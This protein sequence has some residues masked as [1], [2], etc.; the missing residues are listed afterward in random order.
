MTCGI[1]NYGLSSRSCCHLMALDSSIMAG[2]H[3]QKDVKAVCF[4]HTTKIRL[5]VIAVPDLA[6]SEM[7]FLQRPTRAPANEPDKAGS[8]S[9]EKE[10]RRVEREQV[11][12]STFFKPRGEPNIVR[13]SR[14]TS[15]HISE[16]QPTSMKQI[17]DRYGKRHLSLQISDRDVTPGQRSQFSGTY[18]TP[19]SFSHP[20][21]LPRQE[22]DGTTCVTWSETQMTPEVT[23]SLRRR[24]IGQ[25]Q[26][27]PIPDSIR[28]SLE[29]TGIFRDTGIGSTTA[30]NP[31]R[32][33]KSPETRTGER[34]IPSTPS[35]R[36]RLLMR[37]RNT[38][39]LSESHGQR[40]VL[41]KER[42]SYPDDSQKE[43][44]RSHRTHE[45][46]L[47]SKECPQGERS[48]PSS[49][50]HSG[51]IRST[52]PP[53]ALSRSQNL[54]DSICPPMTREQLAQKARIRRQPDTL[55]V[56][57]KVGMPPNKNEVQVINPNSHDGQ[58]K[59]GISN[60]ND[61]TPAECTTTLSKAVETVNRSRVEGTAHHLQETAGQDI[62]STQP[63][64]PIYVAQPQVTSI[65]EDTGCIMNESPATLDQ[66]NQ[67]QAPLIAANYATTPI[68]GPFVNWITRPTS[69]APPIAEY[70]HENPVQFRYTEHIPYELDNIGEQ[71]GLPFEDEN[72]QVPTYLEHTKYDL[73][74]DEYATLAMQD[75]DFVYDGTTGL[76]WPVQ[77]IIPQS[78]EGQEQFTYQEMGDSELWLGDVT[79]Q[80]GGD[81]FSRSNELY[82]A[83]TGYEQ[84]NNEADDTL[85]GFWRPHRTY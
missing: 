53:A 44:D 28:R 39:L 9:R 73:W 60:T 36:N 54:H 30:L 74:E 8:K 24:N 47:C 42:N 34:R 79:D 3:P 13:C 7:M 20:N 61:S 85:R 10:R 57:V 17:S 56:S 55:P 12:I 78:L 26:V 81:I 64:P 69:Q 58:E 35:N 75:L 72:I 68:Q 22:P 71:Y 29:E 27:S 65:G 37:D 16:E 31:S 70:L 23:S 40:S 84:A 6:S 49:V 67:F 14:E 32:E 50:T 51:L 19:R 80:I 45:E 25:P 76:E 11:E 66:T 2:L 38:T 1:T 48:P 77:P 46:H 62:P 33:T 21:R 59:V 41:R 4:N 52:P 63:S 5:T 82:W 18:C 83:D 43:K 15:T